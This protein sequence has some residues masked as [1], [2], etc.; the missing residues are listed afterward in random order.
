MISVLSSSPP[1]APR[2][3]TTERS[4]AR[5]AYMPAVIP[6]GPAPM[7]TTSYSCV[8]AIRTLVD[9][10]WL[11]ARPSAGVPAS[12]VQDVERPVTVRDG[13]HQH[14]GG[15]VRRRARDHGVALEHRLRVK[16]PDTVRAMLAV[17]NDRSRKGCTAATFG[18][19]IRADG[20]RHAP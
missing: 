6:A 5:P 12:D 15:V 11:N 7:I 17:K 2:S 13:S 4:I 18:L 20:G 10:R 19:D 14:I 1:D 16:H 3:S 8:V 9:L